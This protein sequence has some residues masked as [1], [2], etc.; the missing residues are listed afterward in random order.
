MADVLET[1]VAP[2][3]ESL[4]LNG[5]EE[6]AEIANG[7]AI[8]AVSF[9]SFSL[10]FPVLCQP[11]TLGFFALRSRFSFFYSSAR[12]EFL[13]FFLFFFGLFFL[14]QYIRCTHF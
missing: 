4:H 3:L 8:D 6:Q 5:E 9:L 7:I 11:P 14:S 1:T 13:V 2:S 12:K 10:F